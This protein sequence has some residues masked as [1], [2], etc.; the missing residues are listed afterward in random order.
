MTGTPGTGKSHFAMR[1]SGSLDSAELI[2]INDI[3]E[4]YGLFSGIDHGARVVKMKQLND[5]LKKEIKKSK[6]TLILVGHLAA[7]MGLRYDICIVTRSSLS[8]LAGVFKERGYSAKKARENLF[9]EALDYCGIEAGKRSKEVYEVETLKSKRE[10]ID[11]AR[12]RLAG[13]KAKRPELPRISKMGELLR[14][15]KS[16]GIGL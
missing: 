14:R 13:K 6:H 15:I 4:R 5:A 16:G 10:V 12:A 1:L 8:R 3:V 9:A 7:E 11:Y 2:E